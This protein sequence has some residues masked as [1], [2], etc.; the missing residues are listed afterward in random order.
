MKAKRQAQWLFHV[1]LLGPNCLWSRACT[2]VLSNG[3]FTGL[4]TYIS[5][6][7]DIALI[8]LNGSE[9]KR[10]PETKILHQLQGSNHWQLQYVTPL[11]PRPSTSSGCQYSPWICQEG[12]LKILW[13]CQDYIRDSPKISAKSVWTTIRVRG[14]YSG[15]L[16]VYP[17]RFRT[18][19]LPLGLM[20]HYRPKN[21]SKICSRI[22]YELDTCA[23]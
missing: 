20:L 13:F 16:L 14:L 12:V 7:S 9:E 22:R 21:H 8:M 11:T 15:V 17:N 23:K 18:F 4:Q 1:Q 5:P 2:Q 10:N 3:N 6:F 19:C